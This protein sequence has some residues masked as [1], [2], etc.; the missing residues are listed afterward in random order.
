LVCFFFSG[1]AGLI[2]EVAWTK[3][4]G[5]LFGHTVYANAT[6]LAAFMAGL[7]AG[8]AWFGRKSEWTKRPIALYGWIE[9]GVAVT[10]AGSLAGLTGVH[11]LYYSG[12]SL[13]F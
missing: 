6:V 12:Y 3:S 1:A 2:Y 5:L 9:L 10:G 11:W 8:S 4:L 7:A 13:V